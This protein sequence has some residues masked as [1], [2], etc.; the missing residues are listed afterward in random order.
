VGSAGAAGAG[1]CAVVLRGGVGGLGIGVGGWRV[2][3]IAGNQHYGAVGDQQRS[4]MV[5]ARSNKFPRLFPPGPA[6]MIQLI[7]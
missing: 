1:A 2:S 7:P 6:L 3:I 4:G 5:C